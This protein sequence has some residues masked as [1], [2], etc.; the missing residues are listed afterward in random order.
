M[1]KI[2]DRLIIIVN[3]EGISVRSLEQRIG[4]SNGV[5]SKCMS[6]GTDISS[7]W[8]SKIIDVLPHYRAEW[9]FT[10]RGE[11]LKGDGDNFTEGSQISQHLQGTGDI[12]CDVCKIKDKLIESQ[13]QQIKMLTRI[14]NQLE[15]KSQI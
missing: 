10:G 6:R 3:R 13:E 15:E 11:M 12:P 1:E 4:C 9:I 5:L 7:L 14:L 2:S 8:L